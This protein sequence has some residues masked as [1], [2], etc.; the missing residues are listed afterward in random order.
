[1][2]QLGQI[3]KLQ[4]LRLTSVG[5]FLGDDEGNDILLPNKYIPDGLQEGDIAEVFVYKDSE[6]RVIATTLKPFIALHEFAYLEV[7]AV[8]RVGAFVEWGLEKN[9]LIPFSE[10]NPP[11]REGQWCT[12]YL[13]FDEKSERLVGSC[14]TNRYLE[15]D[16]IELEVGQAVEVLVYERSD[17]GFNVI[18]NNKY[19]GLIYAN[20]IF[21]TLRLGHQVTAYIKNI[22]EDK[23]I[24]VSLQPIGFEQ[25][26]DIHTTK[27]LAEL[28]ANEGFLPLT[29]ASQPIAIYARL[30]MSKKNFKKAVGNLYR[31]RQ[32]RIEENGIYLI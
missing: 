20:E 2:Y 1:M 19:R 16:N 28:K 12:V 17:L 8:T 15:F 10:Q 26:I 13:L 24:D 31:Q 7:V 11:L 18:I 27:L 30:D 14:K 29:D 21:Q 6:D 9:L 32:L 5:M 25:S 23:G 3:N 22:R 4:V